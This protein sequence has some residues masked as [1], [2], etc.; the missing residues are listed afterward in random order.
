MAQGWTT[1]S[2]VSFACSRTVGLRTEAGSEGD[3]LVWDNRA[4]QVRVVQPSGHRL[5]KRRLPADTHQLQEV[6][7]HLRV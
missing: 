1:D 3:A 4:L 7:R 5:H 2:T 6:K